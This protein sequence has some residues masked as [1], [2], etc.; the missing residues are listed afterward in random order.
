VDPRYV[1]NNSGSLIHAT[2]LTD[3]TAGSAMFS[4]LFSLANLR[5]THYGYD[6]VFSD[7]RREIMKS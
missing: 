6:V 5:T 1:K 2:E 7:G 3:I 4:A